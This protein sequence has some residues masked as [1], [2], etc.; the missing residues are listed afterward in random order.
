[1]KKEMKPTAT[2][3]YGE[4]SSLSTEEQFRFYELCRSKARNN[5]IGKVVDTLAKA[6]ACAKQ[7]AERYKDQASEYRAVLDEAVK[8]SRKGLDGLGE[9]LSYWNEDRKALLAAIEGLRRTIKN[10]KRDELIITI[11]EQENMSFGQIGKAQR[12]RDLNGG[13][14]MKADSV[15]KQYGRIKNR[16]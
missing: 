15:K 14:A 8:Q 1:M 7:D 3:V 10:K 16:R 2:A 6:L 5:V 12:L 9:A 4:F 13:Q 11:R